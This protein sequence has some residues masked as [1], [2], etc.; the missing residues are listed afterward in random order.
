M[1]GFLLTI[2]SKLVSMSCD[3]AFAEFKLTF[4]KVYENNEEE[5]KAIFCTNFLD[6]QELLLTDPYL[7]VGLVEIMDIIPQEIQNMKTSNFLYKCDIY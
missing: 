2:Q 4:K 3:E 6:L 7:P 5:K 1:I